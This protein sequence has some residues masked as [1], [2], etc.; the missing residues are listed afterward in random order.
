MINNDTEFRQALNGM[1]LEQQR[2]MAACFAEN[3]LSLSDDDRI[4]G[5]VSTVIEGREIEDAFKSAKAASLEAHARCGAEGD[6]NDQAGYFVARAAQA[7]VEPQVRTGGKNP[8][9]KAAMQARMARTCLASE[10]GEDSHDRETV[11]QYKIL[12]DYLGP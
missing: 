11:A 4:Q 1:D 8:A 6:W 9:W 12:N 3:V 5:V 10:E 7:A 2:V